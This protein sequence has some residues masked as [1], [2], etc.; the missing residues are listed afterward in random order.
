MNYDINTLISLF[1]AIISLASFFGLFYKMKYQLEQ[2]EKKQ[3]KFLESLADLVHITY[4]NKD[5]ITA[6]QVHH[7]EMEK[8]I[9]EL[10]GVHNG[11]ETHV[12]TS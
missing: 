10:K 2:M 9:A 1:S 5:A 7:Q 4:E 8:D 11:R 6:L 3:E 12:R